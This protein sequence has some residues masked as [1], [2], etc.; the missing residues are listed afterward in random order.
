LG[1][2]ECRSRKFDP[3]DILGVCLAKIPSRWKKVDSPCGTLRFTSRFRRHQAWR[4]EATEAKQRKA[5]TPKQ[6]SV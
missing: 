6:L 4:L 1:I 5:F 3:A 2:A